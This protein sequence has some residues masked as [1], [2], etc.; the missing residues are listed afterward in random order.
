MSADAGLL[1][2]DGARTP[3]TR[4]GGAL[5]G[6]GGSELARQ[7]ILHL[8]QGRA[9]YREGCELLQLGLERAE[10]TTMDPARRLVLRTG[11]DERCLGRTTALGQDAGLAGIVELIR[12]TATTG[13]GLV[14]AGGYAATSAELGLRPG[15]VRG[16]RRRAPAPGEDHAANLVRPAEELGAQFGFDRR[17]LDEYAFMSRRRARMAIGRRRR[18]LVP[19]V[20]AT[21]LVDGDR[22]AAAEEDLDWLGRLKTLVGPE[23]RCTA[24]HLQIPADGAAFLLLARSEPRPESGYLA[25]LRFGC[26]RAQGTRLPV[27]AGLAALRGLLDQCG[28]GLDQI[29]LFEIHE[30]FAGEILAAHAL[31][32]SAR[33]WRRHRLPG[34]APGEIAG[35]RINVAGGAIAIGHAG[36]A[37]GPRMLLDLARELKQRGARRGVAI[38]AQGGGQASA[39]LVE[40]D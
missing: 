29:D 1:L 8:L 21:E 3:F 35:D 5:A 28:L 24:G 27:V 22:G 2:I 6:L 18:D 7:V 13:P 26:T 16:P 10:S 14:I 33:L 20:T 25:R 15:E 36:A 37:S 12:A 17:E 19:V 23:G 39:V 38:M 9:A 4:A 40:V 32:G 31:A 11:L 34:E 30:S